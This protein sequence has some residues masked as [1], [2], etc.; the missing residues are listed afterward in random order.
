MTDLSEQINRNS[1]GNGLDGVRST[2]NSVCIREKTPYSAD[3]V[4]QLGQEDLRNLTL[5]L[6]FALQSHVLSRSLPSKSGCDNLQSDLLRLISAV[7]SD[8]FDFNRVK[9]LLKAAF[10][11]KLDDATIWDQAYSAVTE[12]TPPPRR[13]ASSV[14]Q[15][16]WLRSTSSFTNSSEHRRYVD[17]ILKEELGTMYV[18]LPGF[19]DAYFG[20]LDGLEAASKEVFDQCLDGHEPVFRNG[21]R[22]WPRDPNEKS[23]LEWLADIVKTLALL[24]KAQKS[25][26][27]HQRSLLIQP[28]TPM[29]G[30]TA[31][32]KLDVGFVDD[33]R[34][35]PYHWKQILVPGE[36]KSNPSAD[37]AS[38]AWIDLGRYAREVLAAQDTR[39]FV[40]GFTLCGSLMRVWA[41]DRLG[42]LASEQFD[43]N[44]DGLQFVS[45]ILGFLWIDEE[46]LGFD[47][48]VMVSDNDRLIKIQRNG[49]TE[50]IVIDGVILRARCV[51]G[52]A[53]TCW[54]AHPKGHPETPLVIKDS[55]QYPE[56]D[57]EGD[58]L[59]E[60][61]D[62]GIVNVARYY[63]HETVRVRETDDDIWNNVRHGLDI[64]AA[65]NYRPGRQIP[66]SK[67]VKDDS[68]KGRPGSS[69]KRPSSQIDSALPP[70][71]RSCSMSPTKVASTSPNRVHRRIILRDYGKPIYEASSRSALLAALVCCIDA[72][73]SLYKAGILHRDVSI[74]N[75][76]I[77]EDSRNPSWPAFLIDLDLA[78][79]E[80]REG[81]SGAKGKTGTRAFMAI[82]A[83]LGEQHSFMHDLESF[84]W[85]LFWICIHYDANGKDVGPTG[86]DRWNYESDNTLAEL[87]M[88]VVADEQYFLQKLTE[89]FTSQ[90]QPL[91]PWVNKLRREVF[92]SGP[93]W[94][95]SEPGLY[96]SMRQ[97]LDDAQKDPEVLANT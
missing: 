11:N 34:G 92:P 78:I 86:F 66:P 76:M 36:L 59:R 60:V 10:S 38:K 47:P 37:T 28:N 50:Q 9:R 32:R 91:V 1:I 80:P 3:L 77:N 68:R 81:S 48:T 74:N 27:T 69:K 5:P 93:K 87:K 42:A 35:P 21:W 53:V 61:T 25:N 79:R 94:N 51:A 12:T 49:S 24:A 73:E 23:V 29:H 63:H 44:K 96:S 31:D 30:S 72:H 18:G 67:M 84:F 95:R 65:T 88:G 83:L 7:V 70:S 2:F 4:N 90:Y 20:R 17:D 71:K 41:F 58:L 54:K 52:R 89:S 19:R 85:V 55:W 97:V 33:L 8:N 43:I 40:M 45:V 14:Q 26:A 75:L 6:L 13:F 64:T 16:P 39:R 22:G 15:T 82:G 62:K 56:R 46:G 57:E